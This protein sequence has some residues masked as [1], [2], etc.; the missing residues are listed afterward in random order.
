[1]EPGRLWGV[2]S[3]VVVVV[4]MVHDWALGFGSRLFTMSWLHDLIRLRTSTAKLD[5]V[6]CDMYL[7]DNQTGL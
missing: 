1:M 4:A 2:K 3:G 7:T 5:L 6:C